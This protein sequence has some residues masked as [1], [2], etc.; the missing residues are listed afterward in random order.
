MKMQAVVA[1]RHMLRAFGFVVHM[2]HP[3]RFVL[4]YCQMLMLRWL[5]GWV[6]GV[7]WMLWAMPC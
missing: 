4:N 7:G 2:E 6:V 1:E 5:A 3:H